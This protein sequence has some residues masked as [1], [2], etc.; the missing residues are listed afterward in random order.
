MSSLQLDHIGKCYGTVEVIPDLSLDVRQGEFVVFL[1][2]S[3]CGKTSLLRMVAGLESITRGRV[4]IGGDDVTHRAPGQRNLAMVFQHYAL[5]PHMTVRDNLSFGLHNVGVAPAEIDRRL[6]EAARMLELDSLLQRR[7][8]QLSGGQR[9][10]VAIGRAVVKEPA[11]FLF[12]E[13][14]SNL[15]A[16]LRGR[17]RVE[18]ARLHQR[19]GATMVFVTHDQLEAMTLATRIV[20]MNKGAI[21]QVGTPA[22]IYRRPAT[23]FVASFI[24]TPG[25]NLIPVQRSA[26]DGLGH[27]T[28]LA[29]G[30]QAV[31]TAVPAAGVPRGELTLGVRPEN[32]VLAEQGSLHGTVELVEFLGER[33]LVHVTLADGHTVIGTAGAAPVQ[34]G[35]AVALAAQTSELQLFDAQ[36]RAHAA[37]LVAAPAHRAAA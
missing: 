19:L 16:A 13:P 12:D 25:M 11:L 27:C 34:R 21:E 22:E 29:P 32:L 23:R 14:L 26:D 7:P 30:G 6:L 18:L 36:G 37:P 3:G 17:T 20:V 1:G 5:Y 8:D 28:V 31:A 2:P 33:T 35:E 4:L 9:Q 10:R 15:D 24:G